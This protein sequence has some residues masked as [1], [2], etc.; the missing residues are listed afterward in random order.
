MCFNYF[1]F[2]VIIFNLFKHNQL[3]KMEH[4]SKRITEQS[5][6]KTDPSMKNKKVTRITS[7]SKNQSKIYNQ[8]FED[9][10]KSCLKTFSTPN[11]VFASLLKSELMTI[12]LAQFDL[13]EIHCI[14]KLIGKYQY[15]KE[16]ILA[17][18]NPTSII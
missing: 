8:A 3:N 15:F 13:K 6:K 5:T 1:L 10:S 7:V 14:N 16:M 9:Y 2:N 11:P 18:Y 17:P 4:E 12:Y